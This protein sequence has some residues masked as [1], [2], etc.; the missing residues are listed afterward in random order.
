VPGADCPVPYEHLPVTRAR[1]GALT[2]HT[3]LLPAG[4]YVINFAD[5]STRAAQ[6]PGRL[7]LR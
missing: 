7:L 3:L 4:E 5:G 1:A 6:V 2:E